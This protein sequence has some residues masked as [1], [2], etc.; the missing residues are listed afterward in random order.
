MPRRTPTKM[1]LGWGV[2]DEATATLINAMS[3]RPDIELVRA[4]DDLIIGLRADGWWDE[5]GY[6]IIPTL[7]NEADSLLDWKNPGQKAV[8]NGCSF[9]A[10]QGLTGNG[11]SAYI[12][13]VIPS[14]VPGITLDGAHHFAWAE[15]GTGTSRLLAHA[16]GSLQT[17]LVPQGA[18]NF[19]ARVNGTSDASFGAIATRNGLRHAIRTSSSSVSGY[20]QGALAATVANNSV[21]IDS[22]DV[23]TLLRATTTYADDRILAFGIGGPVTAD[24]ADLY[25][26]L[27]AFFDAIGTTHS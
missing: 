17:S 5:I 20:S 16:A 3:T 10:L 9:T 8:N 12:D 18:T 27:D 13:T 26:R 21:A 24:P 14:A 4:I 22:T 1:E 19:T 2:G 7:H 11:T 15:D 25:S 23:S 6:L